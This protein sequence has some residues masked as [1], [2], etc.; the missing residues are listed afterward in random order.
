MYLFQTLHI[1]YTDVPGTGW[2]N[3]TIT[4][5]DS[6]HATATAYLYIEVN[7]YDD[8]PTFGAFTPTTLTPTIAPGSAITFTIN[9]YDEETRTVTRQWYINGQL[10]KSEVSVLTY[11]SANDSQSDVTIRADISDG[12]T[13]TQSKTWVEPYRE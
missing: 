5:E 6:N 3:V 11:Q 10:N 9:P 7:E 13:T 2:Q 12:T 8:A 1:N 4:L